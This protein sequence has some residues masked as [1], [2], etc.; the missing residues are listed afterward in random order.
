MER[1]DPA[2]HITTI[3]TIKDPWEGSAK[4]LEHFAR[5]PDPIGQILQDYANNIRFVGLHYSYPFRIYVAWMGGRIKDL[6]PTITT[7][8]AVRDFVPNVDRFIEER[9]GPELKQAAYAHAVTMYVQIWAMYEVFL[10]RF[11]R[12]TLNLYPDLL[13]SPTN[14][15][16]KKIVGKAS[17]KLGGV[18]GAIVEDGVT[19]KLGDLLVTERTVHCDMRDL[20][21]DF[22]PIGKAKE[23]Q[24]AFADPWLLKLEKRRH[25]VTHK[26]GIV[27][28]KYVSETG[29]GI[30]GTPLPVSPFDTFS[31]Y[32]ATHSVA[33]QLAAELV[34]YFNV[35]SAARG[36][37]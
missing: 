6:L 15:D 30:P 33:F 24:D 8:Q 36:K 25:V 14:T 13:A 2:R 26:A 35:L 21:L 22:D 5:L 11:T 1:I 29:E 19:R 3:L 32:K 34:D 17:A 4:T 23:V 20:I 37:P 7:E 31:C 12:A 10:R 28:K 18:A 27:D 16:I 9:S